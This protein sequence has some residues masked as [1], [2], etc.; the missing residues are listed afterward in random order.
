MTLCHQTRRNFK[1]LNRHPS[2]ASESVLAQIS[3]AKR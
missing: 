2:G 1:R 3:D